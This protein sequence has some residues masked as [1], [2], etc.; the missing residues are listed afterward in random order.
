MAQ[1]AA[2][3]SCKQQV[4]GSSPPASSKNSRCRSLA[5]LDLAEAFAQDH[6]IDEACAAVMDALT[7]RQENRV[8][9]ILRRAREVRAS[10]EPWR[11]E[12]PVK[13]LD[14]QLRPLLSA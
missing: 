12:R 2:Q 7:I 5:R 6:A 9:P 10:L 8:G 14:E 11:D 13:E 3:L 4:G 1:P